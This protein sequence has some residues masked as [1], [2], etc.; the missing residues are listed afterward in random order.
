MASNFHDED[1]PDYT[2]LDNQTGKAPGF[3]FGVR[4]NDGAS[5]STWGR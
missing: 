4:E 5:S 2:D 1:L 3:T